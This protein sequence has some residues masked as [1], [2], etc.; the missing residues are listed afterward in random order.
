LNDA[1]WTDIGNN[2][3]TYSVTNSLNP[4]D[5]IS[6]DITVTV[7][8]SISGDVVNVVEILVDDGDDVDS[9]T[10]NDN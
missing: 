6:I 10:N 4:G 7:D 8:N 9:D 2:D 3:A 1:D 5:S